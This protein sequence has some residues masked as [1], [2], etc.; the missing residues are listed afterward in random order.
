MKNQKSIDELF[1]EYESSEVIFVRALDKKK[2]SLQTINYWRKQGQLKSVCHGIVCAPEKYSLD[3]ECCIA[4]FVSQLGHGI[5][6]GAAS[7]LAIY[8][9]K[10]PKL[11]DD[12]LVVSLGEH[13]NNIPAWT[14]ASMLDRPVYMFR[15]NLFPVP[16]TRMVEHNGILVPVSSPE[17]ALMECI[18]LAATRCYRYED[19]YAVLR[20]M[21]NI[22][23]DVIQRLL[24]TMTNKKAKRMFLF[25]AENLGKTWFKSLDLTRIRLGRGIYVAAKHGRLVNKYHIIVPQSIYDDGEFDRN[26]E[27]YGIRRRKKK[28]LAQS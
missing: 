24:E 21:K 27:K 2:Y 8:G 20:Q 14:S 13:F 22:R 11:P 26:P 15:T 25:M 23:V 3:T 4:D 17:E 5:R 9:Y 16:E 1:S 18:M 19:I 6:I 7:A 10:V 28:E 12:A